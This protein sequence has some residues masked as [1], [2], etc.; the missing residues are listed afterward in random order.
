M[1]F[2][3]SYLRRPANEILAKQR[4]EMADVL[5]KEQEA[6]VAMDMRMAYVKQLE[7]WKDYLSDIRSYFKYASIISRRSGI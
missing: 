4:Q 1:L 7:Y 6:K 3:S 5:A 2:R